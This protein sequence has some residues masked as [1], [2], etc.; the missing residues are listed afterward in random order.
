MEFR[1]DANVNMSEKKENMVTA[2]LQYD[3][4]VL[5]R[6]FGVSTGRASIMNYFADAITALD[7]DFQHRDPCNVHAIK[8]SLENVR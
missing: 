4:S 1:L 3:T 7:T 2:L 6:N 8:A 5:R